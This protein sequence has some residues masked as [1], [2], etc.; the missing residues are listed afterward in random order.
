[1][2]RTLGFARHLPNCGWNPILLVP[3]LQAYAS[4]D[5]RQNDLIPPSARIYRSICLDAA[6]HLSVLGRYPGIL[7]RPDRWTSWI[8]S[9]VF[10]GL[11][12]IRRHK[13]QV[14]WSTY[15]IATSHIIA[16][17]LARLTG[18]PWIA[19]FR[20]PMV[21]RDPKT[22]REFPF[23]RRLRNARLRVESTCVNHASALV[24]CT[25]WARNI[26]IDRYEHISRDTCHVI[27]NG[28]E[29][30]HFN[31]TSFQDDSLHPKEPLRRK[32]LH[33]GTIYPTPDRDPTHFFDAVATLK[34]KGQ[35]NSEGIEITLR[36]TGHDEKMR[37]LIEE[38]NIQDLV[39]IEPPITYLEALEE[40][41][42]A[43]GLLVFQGYTSNPAIPAKVY[44]YLRAR[45]PIFALV[46]A[47]GS[48][49]QLLRNLGIE[50]T[51]PMEDA[52]LIEQSLMRFLESIEKESY[53]ELS[54]VQIESFSR[55]SLTREFARICNTLG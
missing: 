33:S 21:E 37:E 48:T 12:V 6:R 51:A 26:C 2:Q 28:Y 7:A 38:R 36:A 52:S 1:M 14:I 45:R 39:R 8:P 47:E 49:A 40:M 13:P 43:D 34:G 3:S 22:G 46:D 32:L 31:N 42:L 53:P 44:E 27:S 41:M 30:E 35:I 17:I 5:D 55:S 15:P 50:S 54:D 19:D 9:A 4:I 23:D 10:Q 11:R 18:I 24:F 20:D 16:S 29:E 25:E